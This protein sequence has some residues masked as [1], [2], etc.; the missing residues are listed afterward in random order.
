MVKV[1][2]DAPIKANVTANISTWVIDFLLFFGLG[3]LLSD[4]S[5][6]AAASS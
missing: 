1:R 5:T 6:A 2:L 4:H 3:E